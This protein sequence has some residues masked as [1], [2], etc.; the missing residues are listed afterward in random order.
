MQK[1]TSLMRSAVDKYSMIDAGDR[2]AVGVSGGK[3]SVAL[4]CG[5]AALR[6]FY[7]KPFEIHAITA[8]PCFN[9]ENADYSEIAELCA[10]LHIPYTIRRTQLG[11]V[12]F[13]TRKE[14]NPCSL[15]ARMR[16]GF[17]TTWQR[18]RAV[19]SLPS[20]IMPTT[21]RKPF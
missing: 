12:I 7:P 13:E 19:T 15:C 18:S 10:R 17:C 9:H 4:L 3:D 21:R 11:T 1:I 14:S 2:I 8:D 16:R 5:P 6:R 20:D